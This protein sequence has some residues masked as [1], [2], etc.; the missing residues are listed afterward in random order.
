MLFRRCLKAIEWCGRDLV[1]ALCPDYAMFIIRFSGS[2][3]G[4][5]RDRSHPVDETGMSDD[6]WLTNT[7]QQSSG[8]RLM[9]YRDNTLSSR[10]RHGAMSWLCI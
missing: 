6:V 7:I 1:C 2:S 4:D 3:I 9:S 8:C 10:P 5:C